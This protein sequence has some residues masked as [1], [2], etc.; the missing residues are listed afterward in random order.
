MLSPAEMEDKIESLIG[1]PYDAERFHCWTLVEELVPEAPKLKVI[2]G[3]YT[4]A[5]KQF[6][7]Q[8]NNNV[9][10]YIEVR[11]RPQSSD[12]VLAGNNYINH[13][14]VLVEEDG[15]FLVVHNDKNGVHVEPMYY[16][17]K[18]YKQIRIIRC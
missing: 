18:N 12:I 11:E 5:I 15:T 6:K 3:N 7:E 9:K 4:S 13:A 17:M 10:Q 2:G 8:I 14:G 1:R 16:F